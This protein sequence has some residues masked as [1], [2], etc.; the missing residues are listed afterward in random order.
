M[1]RIYYERL[2]TGSVVAGGMGG[3]RLTTEP[4][5]H[6]DFIGRGLGPS[7]VEVLRGIRARIH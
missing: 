6:D 5:V 2:A 7:I 4:W 1:R 3:G